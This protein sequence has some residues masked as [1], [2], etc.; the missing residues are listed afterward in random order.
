MF[1]VRAALAKRQAWFAT[2]WPYIFLFAVVGLIGVLNHVMWRDEFNTWLI[3]RDSDS[4]LD[5]LGN[6]KYQ[7]H[8]ALWALSLAF[9]RNFSTSPVIMQLFH[10][11]IAVLS[12]T[13]FW[14]WSPFSH[15][16]KVLFTFGY[17]PFYEY[18]IVAR[19]YVLGMLFLFVFCALLPVRQKTYIPAAIALA[20]LAN[21]SAYGLFIAIAL[22]VML[23][24]EWGWH[25]ERRSRYL[26]QP[27]VTDLILSLLI[28]A[29]GFG[30]ATYILIP[31]VDS[32]NHGGLDAWKWHFDLRRL[33]R[34][35]GRIFA[36][37]TLIVPSQ[38]KWSD[39]IIFG[40]LT[41]SGVTIFTLK[42]LTKPLA[43]GFF[44]LANGILLLFSYVRFIGIG[45]RHFA[46]FYLILLAAF[47]WAAKLPATDRLTRRLA[48]PKQWLVVA[49]QW[50]QPLLTGMLV[51]QFIVGLYGIPRDLLI[52]FSASRETANF[53]QA[54]GWQDAFMVASRDANMAP[55]SGYLDRQLYY[56]ELQA[57][58]SFTIF[59]REREDD[60]HEV[61]MPHQQVLAQVETL[62]QR[63]AAERILLILHIPLEAASEQLAIAPIREFTRSWTPSER[64]YLYWVSLP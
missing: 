64:Y 50:W 28:V 7:G 40:G 18:L 20:L 30:F 53:I 35:W 1:G 29:I 43:G 26:A 45:P 55:I 37:Y 14:L 44:L 52:P 58:G 63:G 25:G 32:H 22:G 16:Q 56:P 59:G 57:L 27:P 10:W 21:S 8:T 47:W 33:L 19:P 11:A 36:G 5:M 12:V 51:I 9:L 13:V 48:V 46:H 54:A 4:L 61:Y 41:L 24:V 62:L 38:H 39:L 60:Y 23:V 42:L 2:P 15:R 6:V 3:V 34:T 49:Q 17:V 31:P